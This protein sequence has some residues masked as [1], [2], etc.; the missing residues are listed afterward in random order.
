MPP[1]IARLAGLGAFGACA[2]F[3]ALYAYVAYISRHTPTG[4]MMPVLSAVTWISVGLVVLALIGV[5]VVLAKQLFALA[6]GGAQ[7]V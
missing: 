2:G 7:P 5:H 1:K 4:G 3:L 6:R